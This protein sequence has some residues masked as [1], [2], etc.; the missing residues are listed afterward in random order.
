MMEM[1][2]DIIKSNESPEDVATARLRYDEAKAEDLWIQDE[3]P[4]YNVWPIANELAE[5]VKLELPFSKVVL[6][7]KAL[8]LRFAR[9]HEPFGIATAMLQWKPDLNRVHVQPIT[10]EKSRSWY[11]IKYGPEETVEDTLAR[12]LDRPFCET[13]KNESKVMTH[14]LRLVVFVGLLAHETDLIT[15]IVLSKDQT[16]YDSTDDQSVKQW[17]EERAARR[18]G[19]GFDVGKTLQ[20]RKDQSPHWRNPHLCLF[21]TGEG[22]T[23]PVIKMRSGAVVQQ[24]SMAE[25]PTGYLGPETTDNDQLLPDRTPRES[26]S[27]ARRFAILKRD[28]YRCQ[29]CGNSQDDGVKLHVDHRRPL[30]I[31]GSNED[32]NLWTLCDKCN[33]GKSDSEL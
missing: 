10:V 6:P 27:K 28:G 3:R 11:I 22:R 13:P 7:Y 2:K 14:V 32:D 29:L 19:R 12:Y 33:L 8:L 23:K 31:G 4:Y 18:A 21:W 5:S 24:V 26:I 17:L 15:P 16:K 20:I 1:T 30:A 25:V 9:G